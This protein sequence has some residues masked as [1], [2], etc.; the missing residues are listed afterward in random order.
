MAALI[1]TPVAVMLR[2]LESVKRIPVYSIAAIPRQHAAGCRV[3]SSSYVIWAEIG[4]RPD[5]PP[6]RPAPRLA[7]SS[8][9]SIWRS[10]LGVAVGLVPPAE[11]AICR[12]S[13]RSHG[14]ARPKL[15]WRDGLIYGVR[16]GV[17]YMGY[18][19][20]LRVAWSS[21]RPRCSRSAAAGS[22]RS[23]G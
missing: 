21:A 23:P 7:G 17:T 11:R 16:I 9:G 5:D 19:V 1:L 10:A 18:V 22:T 3:H 15:T 6:V 14:P 4:D 8:S 2:V 12:L 13:C 20:F